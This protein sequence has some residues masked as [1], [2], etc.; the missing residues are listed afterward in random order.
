MK[1]ILNLLLQTQSQMRILHWQT[2]SYARHMAFGGF[3]DAVDDLLDKLIE[4]YQGKYGRIYFEDSTTLTI[5][6]ISDDSNQEMKKM[7]IKI[8]SIIEKMAE[9]EK[10]VEENRTMMIKLFEKSEPPAFYNLCH[11]YEQKILLTAL[12]KQDWNQTKTAEYLGIHRNTLI[13]KMKKFKLKSI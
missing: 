12:A 6:D 2:T 13:K 4:C 10:I 5:K 7:T 8:N 9:F 3:Y 11:K 1:E